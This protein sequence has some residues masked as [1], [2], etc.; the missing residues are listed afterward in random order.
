M[1]VYGSYNGDFPTPAEKTIQ[2]VWQIP[3]YFS[4]NKTEIYST[5]SLLQ[6]SLE[7]KDSG[8][9]QSDNLYGIRVWKSYSS[10]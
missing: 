7:N 3:N 2:E 5:R 10:Y 9:K 4:S 8:G 6:I 1:Q